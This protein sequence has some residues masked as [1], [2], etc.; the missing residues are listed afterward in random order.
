MGKQWKQWH[1][2]FLGSKITAEG[3]AAKNKRYSLLGRKAMAN[4]NSILKIRYISLPT[5]VCIVKAMIFLVVICDVRVGPWRRLSTE[6]LTLSNNWCFLT[7][8]LEK[9]LESPLDCKEI[10]PV[11]PKGN[12]V[13]IFTGRTDAEVEASILWPPDAKSQLIIKDPNAE[14][15]RR[16]GQWRMRW[17]DGIIDLLNMSLSKRWDTEGQRG[18]ACCSL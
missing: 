15:R 6:E 13:W 1:F 10:K 12:Q 2:L 16:R 18:L 5:R 8:V 7:V 4:L 11:N 14:G 17:L 3:D 9:T